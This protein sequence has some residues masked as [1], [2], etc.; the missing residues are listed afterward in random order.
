MV[1]SICA[2]A[3]VLHKETNARARGSEFEVAQGSTDI[4]NRGICPINQLLTE[5]DNSMS[6]CELDVCIYGRCSGGIVLPALKLIHSMAHLIE[7]KQMRL[8]Q[9][10]NKTMKN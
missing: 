4:K 2:T 9:K 3:G 7:I 10:I 5:V 6:D 1:C 8:C